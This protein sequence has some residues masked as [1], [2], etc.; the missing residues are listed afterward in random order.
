MLVCI[1]TLCQLFSTNS[2][3]Y[4]A[5]INDN[6]VFVKQATN[7][8]CTLASSVMMLRRTAILSGD[9]NWNSITEGSTRNF[10][11]S[12]GVGLKW[13]FTVNGMRVL[14][15]N[16]SGDKKTQLISLLKQYP[17]GIVAYNKGNANQWHAVLLTDYDSATDIFYCA[18]PAGATVGRV[19]LNSS[20]IK[21]GNQAERISKFNYYW[22]VVTPTVSLP[23]QTPVPTPIPTSVPTATPAPTL[24]PTSTPEPVFPTNSPIDPDIERGD[25]DFDY[26]I[27]ANDA[28]LIL[29]HAAILRIL[30][31]DACIAAD[32]DSNQV[33]NAN[34][35][36]LVLK[37]AARVISE[38]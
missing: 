10:A 5:S 33:V 35:A 22:Y 11:W 26:Q 7:N 27:N 15:G 18:D 20:T 37:Y 32:V 31:P 25:V 19:P 9:V 16:L 8:T 23:Q 28:L 21:G 4:A 24:V 14:H 38:F 12:E 36:L 13:D 1:L 3:V 34:D 30:S 29:Q 6:N 17:Q 2:K